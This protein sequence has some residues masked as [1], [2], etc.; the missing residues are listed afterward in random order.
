MHLAIEIAALHCK[1]RLRAL[2]V[3]D[4]GRLCC[5][6]AQFQLPCLQHKLF[7]DDARKVTSDGLSGHCG[8]IIL[9]K[10]WP[11]E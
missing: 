5:E 10:R 7:A 11:G 3:A 6:V 2:N 8:R 4:G 9:P 1:A